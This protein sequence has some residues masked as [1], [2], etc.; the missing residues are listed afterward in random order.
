MDGDSPDAIRAKNVMEGVYLGVG[1]DVLLGVAQ[2]VRRAGGFETKYLP[3]S[4]TSGAFFE[5]Y[6]KEVPPNETPEE[7]VN[8]QVTQRETATNGVGQ[9]NLEK[10][11][12]LNGVERA[13]DEPMWGVH[14][15]P[16][17]GYQESGIRSADPGGIAL[18]GSD[19][20]RVVRNLGSTNG[21]VRSIATDS[22][23]KSFNDGKMDNNILLRGKG[24]KC[25]RLESMT[26]TLLMVTT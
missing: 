5:R 22:F 19:Y 9:F 20:S 23:I 25:C 21:R 14:D 26:L 17:Y 13:L 4:E 12:D 11:I 8:R 1:L 7:F 15:Y 16:L 10:S 2:I 24:M 18:A 3:K 6:N